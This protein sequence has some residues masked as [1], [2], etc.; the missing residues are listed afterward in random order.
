[1]KGRK[2]GSLLQVPREVE[3]SPY[4][5]PMP[6]RTS[7]PAKPMRSPVDTLAPAANSASAHRVLARLC[8]KSTKHTEE[9]YSSSLQHIPSVNCQLVL[10]SRHT[11]SLGSAIIYTREQ[12][13]CESL[14]ILLIPTISSASATSIQDARSRLVSPQ[15]CTCLGH[16]TLWV[17]L[18]RL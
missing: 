13:L 16:K 1:M 12:D 15:M 6:P 7:G 3:G 18:G 2:Q 17:K 11:A 8:P 10:F 5:G 9:V 14:T 4:S